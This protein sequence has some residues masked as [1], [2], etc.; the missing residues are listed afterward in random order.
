MLLGISACQT[1]GSRERVEYLAETI[2]EGQVIAVVDSI[3]R[4]AEPGPNFN[5]TAGRHNGETV[6]C[7]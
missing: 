6:L 7:W 4:V 2:S 1:T 5:N 3:R